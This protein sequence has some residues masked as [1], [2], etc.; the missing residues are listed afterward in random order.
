MVPAQKPEG[1]AAQVDPLGNAGGYVFV[2]GVAPFTAQLN[3]DRMIILRTGQVYMKD[4]LID[5]VIAGSLDELAVRAK[6][7]FDNK[8][9]AEE[10]VRT[11]GLPKE[12]GK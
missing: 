11:F 6:D 8:G 12:M 3:S 9:L 10:Y 2:P 7:I 1:I 4:G 5:P